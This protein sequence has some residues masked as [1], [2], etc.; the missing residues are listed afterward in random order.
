MTV[1]QLR[2]LA[3]FQA[4]GGLSV[5]PC[6]GPREVAHHILTEFDML[7]ARI[8][9]AKDHVVGGIIT[10]A[11]MSTLFAAVQAEIARQSSKRAHKRAQTATGEFPGHPGDADHD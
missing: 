7:G 2:L 11:Q 8:F 3:V 1:K 5:M 10:E 6:S 9:L 4:D